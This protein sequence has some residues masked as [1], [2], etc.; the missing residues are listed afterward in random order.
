MTVPDAGSDHLLV[1]SPAPAETPTDLSVAIAASTHRAA[2][3]TGI[4]VTVTVVNRS[5]RDA[6]NARLRLE[7]PPEVILR[8]TSPA[9]TSISGSTYEL[10]LGTFQSFEQRTNTLS[11]DAL[12]PL[13]VCLTATVVS[14][15]PEATPDNNQLTS[16][17][18]E[19]L[20]P[21][22][23]L[24]TSTGPCPDPALLPLAFPPA[25]A[26]APWA[27]RLSQPSA[28][29]G[30]ELRLVGPLPDGFC[31][32][33][34]G[35]LRGIPGT[36][37][38]LPW[39]FD[40]IAAD[41][42]HTRLERR[43]TVHS[44]QYPQDLIAFWPLDGHS[45]DV[46]SGA[47]AIHGTRTVFVPGMAGLAAQTAHD[48]SRNLAGEWADPRPVL[49]SPEL[50]GGAEFGTNAVT[51]ATWYRRDA[52]ARRG[53]DASPR[54]TILALT[55]GS[56]PAQERYLL[57]HPT[58]GRILITDGPPDFRANQVPGPLL[59]GNTWHH[60][61]LIC[62]GR[63]VQLYTNGTLAADA[64]LP[65]PL[66]RQPRLLAGA[67]GYDG[68]FSGS[69]DEI[70]LF[71]GALT[72]ARLA[73]LAAQPLPR[74]TPLPPGSRFPLAATLKDL[75][76]PPAPEGLP[77][78]AHLA[79]AFCGVPTQFTLIRGALPPGLLL[80][81]EGRISG[82]PSLPGASAFTVRATDAEGTAAELRVTLEVPPS[83]PAF[84]LE[85]AEQT[86]PAGGSVVLSAATTRPASL[87]WYF[88]GRPLAGQTAPLLVL[89][90]FS[91]A[92][93]GR[94]H[95]TAENAAGTAQS[96][97]AL[98]TL[99]TREDIAAHLNVRAVELRA[100]GV[101]RLQLATAPGR[102][103]QL[104]RALD[105]A[106]AL[107]GGWQRVQSF[108]AAR[109]VTELL[110]L[111]ASQP[112]AAF[113][114]ITESPAPRAAAYSLED[115]TRYLGIAADGASRPG[116][117]PEY[118]P[119]T[120]R[121]GPF[122]FHPAGASAPAG[123]GMILR[124]PDGAVAASPNGRPIL[125][126]TKV[127]VSFPSRSPIQFDEGGTNRLVLSFNPPAELPSAPLS[128]A[129]LE[130]LLSKPAGAGVRVR[131]FREL[132]FLLRQG[133]FD[134]ALL[135]G[136]QLAWAEADAAPF[137]MPVTSAEDHRARA[138]RLPIL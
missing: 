93:A 94:Y 53:D 119:A 96:Q 19:F 25:F 118:N 128:V 42:R 115:T 16:C 57:L 41:G 82:S 26:H 50:V 107:R 56:N 55:G 39:L 97:S 114:R 92:Q 112:D 32:T 102:V 29:P 116:L 87:Q 133:T 15:T 52:N 3:A 74:S 77:F 47:P 1:L 110:D 132:R 43:L 33:A 136:A 137:P 138:P 88:E 22:C 61:A 121:L 18:V 122:E 51:L 59:A 131:L 69:L 34:E 49:E 17:P 44:G 5:G 109:E 79:P 64:L 40:S 48:T 2:V 46:I 120:G 7:L 98:L 103:Y 99:R 24:A 35:E 45:V 108:T 127:E 10:S 111:L 134:G 67:R 76:L 36:D 90:A 135:R 83:P 75:A 66:L 71:S 6:V 62:E 85:P 105:L 65:Q 89:E 38:E 129:A 125:R 106:S 63:R 73:A 68:Y 23:L 12:D 130:Q 60:L 11:L 70:A 100:D 72:P 54:G 81:A 21:E 113:Y 126:A 104:E 8:S 101:V 123:Q 80:S 31:L 124:F 58:T 117:L 91:S 14:D 30:T 13:R 37:G 84:T 27:I 78:L 95:V 9:F 86:V 28:P 20:R 4:Q